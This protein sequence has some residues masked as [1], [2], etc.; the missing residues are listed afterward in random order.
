MDF[1][2]QLILIVTEQ[3]LKEDL[4]EFDID[5]VMLIVDSIMEARG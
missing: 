1:R 3:V 5:K 4:L 2:D